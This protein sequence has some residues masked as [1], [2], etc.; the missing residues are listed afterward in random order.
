MKKTK[1]CMDDI[2]W[3]IT[4]NALN[5]LRT[6]LINEGRYT[7]AVDDVLLKVIRAPTKK[8]KER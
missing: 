7:D 3:R 8:V 5:D 2:E 6:K 4:I 1:I